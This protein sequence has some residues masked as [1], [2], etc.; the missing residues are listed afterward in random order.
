[1]APSPSLSPPPP[2]ST[3]SALCSSFNSQASTYER[4]LGGATRRIITHI[5]ALLP[6]LPAPATIL[7]N[8]CGPGFATS[9]LLRAYP[10]ARIHAADVAEGMIE[11]VD[12]AVAEKKG[13][14][15]GRVV[16]AVMDG[17]ALGYEDATFDASV[18]SFGIFFFGDPVVGAKE[19]FRT[20]KP[21]GTAVVTCW[22]EVPFYGILRAVQQVV[23]P[24]SEPIVMDV[25]ERWTRR[26]T[27]EET[28]REG[29]FEGVEMHERSVMWWNQ[30][31][32]EAVAGL[33]D[34]FVG[35]VGERWTEGEKEE[36]LEAT[37]KVLQ[38]RAR[39]FVVV[40]EDGRIGLQMVAWIAVA[41]RKN[42]GSL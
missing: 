2:P 1:M 13:L 30:G 28:L 29:G 14:G 10:S 41:R 9:E 33:K 4:R 25:L 7:D 17:V 18:T 31:L 12:R 19:I 34:N 39:E 11:L 15:A 24:G 40:E 5:I 37:K 21:G 23:R 6:A 36:I 35:M 16:T 27:M 22:K 3:L 8:A 42:R 20:L 26:E 38:E 32:E